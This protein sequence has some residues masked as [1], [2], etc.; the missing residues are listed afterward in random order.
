MKTLAFEPYDP[1]HF[2]AD[3]L[4][5]DM[6]HEQDN[7]VISCLACNLAHGGNDVY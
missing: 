1:D 6:S 2:T 4:Y 7:C 3:R 5:N